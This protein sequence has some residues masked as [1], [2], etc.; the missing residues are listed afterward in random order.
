[1][2][3][4]FKQVMSTAMKHKVP[5]IC[6]VVALAAVIA[7]FVY[8]LPS[9][10][11]DVQTQANERVAAHNEV[12]GLLTKTRVLPTVDPRNS[13]PEPLEVFPNQAIIEQGTALKDAVASQAATLYD[14]AVQLNAREQLVR[15]ALPNPSG[16]A[17]FEFRDRYGRFM[18]QTLP[19]EI[20]GAGIPPTQDQVTQAV[21]ARSEEARRMA[22]VFGNANDSQ[23]QL[24]IDKFQ[25]EIPNQMRGEV[26]ATHAV[27]ISPEAL[28]INTEMIS[29]EARPAPETIWYAQLG[30]WIQQDIAEAIKAI[31]GS[32]TSVADSTIKH[33]MSVT[34]EPA[35]YLLPPVAGG[36]DVAAGPSLATNPT[37]PITPNFAVSETGRVSNGMYDVVN[38]DTTLVVDAARV[39]EVLAR[40][41]EG[42]LFY[43]RAI[44]LTAVD[45][46][47][48]S[49]EGYLY[50]PNPVVQLELSCQALFLRRWTEPL[51]PE[52][53]KRQLG[54]LPPLEPTGG[55]PF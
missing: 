25:R 48:A 39:P 47:I 44:N 37:Q 17:G 45:P 53:V 15:G 31:N 2:A 35:P 42:R 5:I 1:M 19:F 8:P 27:Y 22:A 4:D 51:M 52:V 9:M 21:Q 7:V 34:I 26:A 43:I 41:V 40:F 30:L 46:R 18:Q 55:P 36:G 6:G 54:I 11:E 49:A 10:A 50:G 28:S 23:L 16:T 38:F 3:V 29:S 24:S 32:S 33:L 14:A 20:L 13:E 12:N